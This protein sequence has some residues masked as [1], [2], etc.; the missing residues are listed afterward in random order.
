M[1][2]LPSARLLLVDDDPSAIQA[3]SRMLAH[4]P[5]LAQ[6]PVIFATSHTDPA[7]ELAAFEFGAAGFIAKPLVASQ[8]HARVRG[9]RR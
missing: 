9:R 6:V 3:L 4:Y 8:V 7:H 2:L 1:N 5:A